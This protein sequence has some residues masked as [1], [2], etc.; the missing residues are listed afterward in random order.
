MGY[1]GSVAV[2]PVAY[3][4][5]KPPY[6]GW[7]LAG[8]CPCVLRLYFKLSARASLMSCPRCSWF[9]KSSADLASRLMPFAH[10]LLSPYNRAGA[11][12]RTIG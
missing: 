10:S 7:L 8:G 9:A 11:A 1:G 5:P 2:Q 6:A 3:P 4:T 12:R